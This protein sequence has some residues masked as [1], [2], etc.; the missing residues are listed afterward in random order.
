MKLIIK[1]AVREYKPA[2]IWRVEILTII[3]IPNGTE[4]GFLTQHNPTQEIGEA[5]EDHLK[6]LKRAKEKMK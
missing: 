6:L 5:V 1:R 3:D 2:E 4:W